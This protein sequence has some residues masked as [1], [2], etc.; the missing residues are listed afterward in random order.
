MADST[1]LVPP[2]RSTKPNTRTNF[3]PIVSAKTPG[4]P[5]TNHYLDYLRAS[6]LDTLS[7][8]TEYTL[9]TVD[10][11]IAYRPDYISWKSY[12]TTDYWWIV[13]F[14]NKIIHPMRDLYPS[15]VIKIPSLIQITKMYQRMQ[16]KTSN[17]GQIV[18]I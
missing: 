8:I 11:S 7:L 5:H 4:Q 1:V 10:Q 12:G 15:R 6:Y 17:I 14:A 9:L 18:T 13:C 16:A 2:K 3:L